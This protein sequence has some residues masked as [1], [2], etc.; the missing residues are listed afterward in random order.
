MDKA[1]EHDNAILAAREVLQRDYVVIDC[2]TTGLKTPEVC[3][4][5]FINKGGGTFCTLVKPIAAI[6]ASATAVHGITNE[7]LAD[8]FPIDAYKVVL[9]TL[10]TAGALI[11]YNVSYDIDALSRSLRLREVVFEPPKSRVFDVMLCYAAFKGE[12]NPRFGTFRWHKLGDALSHIGVE[13]NAHDAL[14][15]AQATLTLLEYIANQN[16]TWEDALNLA[17]EQLSVSDSADMVA[18]E[19]DDGHIQS[20]TD[21]IVALNE[22]IAKITYRKAPK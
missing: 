3:Q 6:E 5:A 10:S 4:F 16:T 20:N 11:G 17:L 14:A 13:F 8:A 12:I 1:Y 9:G 15:D 7:A 2:E 21:D 22:A 19:G 18:E